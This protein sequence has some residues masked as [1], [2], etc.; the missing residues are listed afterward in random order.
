MTQP[1]TQQTHPC[2]SYPNPPVKPVYQH[3]LACHDHATT[4]L[5]RRN[6]TLYCPNCG[7]NDS[8]VPTEAYAITLQAEIDATAEYSHPVG[9]PPQEIIGGM[10]HTIGTPPFH[11]I[12]AIALIELANQYALG[13]KMKGKDAWNAFSV[14]QH[15]LLNNE[16]LAARLGHVVNHALAMLQALATNQPLNVRDAAAIAWGGTFAISATNARSSPEKEQ[17]L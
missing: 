4:L 9:P 7:W 13:E 10:A 1:Q 5:T 12:P 8:P 3:C 15:V 16:A 6:L 2:P 11:L 17:T 14:N